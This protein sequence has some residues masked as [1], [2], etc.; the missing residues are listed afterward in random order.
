M[1]TK[2]GGVFRSLFVN[3][4][5]GSF[6]KKVR[7]SLIDDITK[8]GG[9]CVEN[10]TEKVHYVVCLAKDKS[11]II[12]KAKELDLPCLAEAWVE[13]CIKAGQL[14]LSDEHYVFAKPKPK[15]RLAKRKRKIASQESEQEDSEEPEEGSNQSQKKSSTS[16]ES[17]GKKIKVIK[18]GRAAVDP[19]LPDHV[20]QAY[21]VLEEGND[22]YDVMLNQTD[23]SYSIKGHN[24]FYAIQ[25]LE[26]D[27]KNGWAVWTR[28]GRVGAKGQSKLEQ[29]SSLSNAKA[30]FESKFSSKTGNDWEDRD[31]FKRVKGKYIMVERDFGS[32][33]SD[34]EDL[35]EK[36]KKALQTKT[37]SKIPES[38]LDE[39]VQK[40]IQLIC[41]LNM[42]Q[43]TL[44]EME[45]DIN[46]MPL[47]KLKKSHID[48][49]YKVLKKLEKVLG[50]KP[51]DK[52][53]LTN[54]TNDFYSLIPHDFGMN[55]PPLISTTKM[56]Q[57]KMAMLEALGDIEIAT[58][59]LKGSTTSDENPIDSSYKAL[60]TV[61]VP[62]SETSED[63]KRISLYIRNTHAPTH[64]SYTLELDSLFSV[65]RAGEHERFA[66]YASLHNHQLLWHGSR[67]TNYVGILS[68]GLRIAPPEAPVTGYMFGK[69]V[70]FADMVTK[71]ANYCHSS[72]SN[73]IGVMLLSRVALGNTYDCLQAEYMD[74][75][76]SGYH[77]TKGCGATGPDPAEAVTTNDGMLIPLGKPAATGTSGSLLY[78]EFIVYDVAQIVI[79]YLVVVKFKY[80]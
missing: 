55:R 62:I 44:V 21:H 12:E 45:F 76:P 43:D 36:Q 58:N 52:S 31:N 79:S 61:L 25:L 37:N 72:R 57:K 53:K 6:T 49:G 74:Q 23:I 67:L 66:N 27:T 64:T 50:T 46:K 18:K 9:C 19:Y 7:D 32:D 34:T 69:G 78:N 47:G 29:C 63:Y 30:T 14:Q 16:N 17:K 56:M 41:N 38:Q 1:T 39:S 4:S 73:P 22:I 70:Y 13:D 15:K 28:W 51:V 11:A 35:V 40:L 3:V 68:Q 65:Q 2:N 24:K 48:K 59:L 80:K 71:S 77:S 8:E 33:N 60:N 20:Q 54:L 75:A 26:K 10:I 42:M 5:S